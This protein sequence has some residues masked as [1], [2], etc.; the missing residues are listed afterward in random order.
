[1]RDDTGL[2]IVNSPDRAPDELK[3]T[4]QI[5]LLAHQRQVTAP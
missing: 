1:M 5:F 3:K 4:P 2:T